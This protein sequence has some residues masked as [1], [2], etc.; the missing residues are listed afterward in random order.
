M[1]DC[2]AD[3]DSGAARE[4]GERSLQNRAADVV[5]IDIDALGTM[6]P[7]GASDVFGFV[8]DSGIEAEVFDDIAALLG[9]PG[10]ADDVA[11]FDFGDLADDGADGPSCGGDDDCFSGL[12]L[13][14]VEESEICGHAG[15]AEDA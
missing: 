15:H 14:G 7:E 10:D 4:V 5:E 2:S 1:R 6:L 9:A 12:G 3:D 11:V 8:I 13:A